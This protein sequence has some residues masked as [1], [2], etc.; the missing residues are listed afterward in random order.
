[1]DEH[2]R[3]FWRQLIAAK[4]FPWNCIMLNTNPPGR[5]R[6]ILSWFRIRPAVR[7]LYEKNFKSINNSYF[8]CC[9]HAT[10]FILFAL[11]KMIAKTNTVV[12][13]NIF[14]VQLR[15]FYS[16]KALF[17]ILHTRILYQLDVTVRRFDYSKTPLVFLSNRYFKKLSIPLYE[18]KYHYDDLLLKKYNSIPTHFKSGKKIL[19]LV[20]D[21]I[22]Y[23]IKRTVAISNWFKAIKT[24]IDENF[25]F[26][27][28]LYK[29]HPNPVFNSKASISICRD[30]EQLPSFMNA[31]FIIA[32][33]RLQFIIGG[34]SAVLS[35][36][37]A[38]TDITA[39]SYL[40]LMPFENE[41]T[42][43][44]MVRFWTQV[45]EG[46]IHFINSL[47]ELSVLLKV[48]SVREKKIVDE[49]K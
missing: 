20:D 18:F 17:L 23:D 32:N 27:E 38:Y 41:K 9:G 4:E 46:K 29:P 19:L 28:V 22:S 26:E 42:K 6:D 34:V 47:E 45:G 12:F 16:L 40:N 10:N 13:L 25:D 24:I 8:F 30:Y 39:I 37:A 44:R 15:R 11:V 1:M 48:T 2:M 7:K 5:F 36:A 35:T 21:C 33:S 31:D 49:Q 14:Y 3:L 43:R